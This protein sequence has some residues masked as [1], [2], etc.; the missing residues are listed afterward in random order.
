MGKQLEELALFLKYTPP[1]TL[2]ED[3]KLLCEVSQEFQAI[4]AGAH[5]RGVRVMAAYLG[6][7]GLIPMLPEANV[8]YFANPPD[9]NV[10][11]MLEE[12]GMPLL[13]PYC[14]SPNEDESCPFD[15]YYWETVLT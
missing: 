9:D 13:H 14:N 10:L 4:A 6:D 2:E 8:N 11:R 1:S 5:D 12:L 7:Q 3:K 15:G